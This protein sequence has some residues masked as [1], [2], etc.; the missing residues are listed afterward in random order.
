VTVAEDVPAG[1]RVSDL[2]A[3]WRNLYGVV[4]YA[5]NATL[6]NAGAHPL[7]AIHVRLDLLDASGAVVASTTGYNLGAETLLDKPDIAVASL[8]PVAPGGRDPLRLTIDKT[9]I[10]RPFAT[11]RLTVV[12]AR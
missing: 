8:S 6:A 10:P 1:V 2:A 4:V 5:V 7:H 12:E 3:E 9:E 11:A